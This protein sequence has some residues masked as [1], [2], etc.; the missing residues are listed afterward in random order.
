MV[1]AMPAPLRAPRRANQWET[2]MAKTET[3]SDAEY[4]DADQF[5]T[6]IDMRDA[7]DAALAVEIVERVARAMELA[8]YSKTFRLH[9]RKHVEREFGLHEIAQSITTPTTREQH[10]KGGLT[11]PEVK[12]GDNA[13]RPQT[14]SLGGT[15]S[16]GT[17][18]PGASRTSGQRPADPDNTTSPNDSA[19]PAEQYGVSDGEVTLNAVVKYHESEANILVAWT[20]LAIFHRAAARAIR[21]VI[22]EGKC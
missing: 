15:G 18:T 12:D 22:T 8:G 21:L 4:I 7:I 2:A 3:M 14:K 19:G 10:D 16:E 11:M 5:P 9:L 6:T 13:V 20:D 1:P 17:R